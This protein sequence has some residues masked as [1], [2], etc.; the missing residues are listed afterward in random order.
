[1]KYWGKYRL[2]SLHAENIFFLGRY[3]KRVSCGDT[4]ERRLTVV[5]VITPVTEV[6]IDDADA[7]N[8][9][10]LIITLTETYVLSDGLGHSV[11]NALEIMELSCQ[12]YL[13]DDNLILRIPRLDVNTVELVVLTLLIP[14]ALEY[15]SNENLLTKED[16]W[17]HLSAM[18]ALPL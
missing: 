7:V 9:L 11:K 17:Q 4:C 15:L 3:A 18:L 6:E 1:M 2:G 16:L 14:L 10:H 5:Q 13:H 8:L 12:L